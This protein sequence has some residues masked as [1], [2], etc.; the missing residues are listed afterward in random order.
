MSLVI[1]VNSKPPVAVRQDALASLRSSSLE[2]DDSGEFR[3]Y[4]DDE[5]NSYY[6]VTTILSNTEPEAK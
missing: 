6:S 5:G 3:T 2:R 4:T 1:D